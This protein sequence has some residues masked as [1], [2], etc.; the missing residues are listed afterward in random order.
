MI[1]PGNPGNILITTRMISLRYKSSS[2]LSTLKCASYIENEYTHVEC[3][4]K[5]FHWSI[6]LI[7]SHVAL[8]EKIVLILVI[9]VLNCLLVTLNPIQYWLSLSALKSRTWNS[10][11]LHTCLVLSAS[12]QSLISWVLIIK[13]SSWICTRYA[14]R[15]VSY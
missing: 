8:N 12:I 9:L 6:L 1:T 11:S 3:P 14:G 15:I 5:S 13:Y 2:M 4:C 7:S 10:H